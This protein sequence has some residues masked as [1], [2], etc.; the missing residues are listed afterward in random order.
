M[1]MRGKTRP[2]VFPECDKLFWMRYMVSFAVLASAVTVSPVLRTVG[3]GRLFYQIPRLRS[4][5][6]GFSH[7]CT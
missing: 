6:Y 5:V 3:Y 7:N 2:F 1:P 4:A